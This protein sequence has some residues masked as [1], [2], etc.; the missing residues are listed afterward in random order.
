MYVRIHVL[1]E[2]PNFRSTVKFHFR[3]KFFENTSPRATKGREP[4]VSVLNSDQDRPSGTGQVKPDHS[5]GKKLLTLQLCMF[6][7]YVSVL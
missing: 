3:L 2:F 4:T 5:G 7:D 1:S 6:S